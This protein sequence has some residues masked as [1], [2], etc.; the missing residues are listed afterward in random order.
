VKKREGRG[1][2]ISNIAN[3]SF[4]VDF[5]TYGDF[6]ALLLILGRRQRDKLFWMEYFH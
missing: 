2:G 4:G 6:A 1:M 3:I 5:R